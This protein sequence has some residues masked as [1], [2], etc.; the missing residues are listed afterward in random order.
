[1]YA[2]NILVPEMNQ[3]CLQSVVSLLQQMEGWEFQ[4]HLIT[5][6]INILVVPELKLDLP[7]NGAPVYMDM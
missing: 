2:D 5:K 1:V 7:I 6:A 3:S 4:E